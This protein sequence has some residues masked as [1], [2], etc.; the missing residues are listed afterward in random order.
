MLQDHSTGFLALIHRVICDLK[1]PALIPMGVKLLSF[2][3][4]PD[5]FQKALIDSNTLNPLFSCEYWSWFPENS[6]AEWHILTSSLVR[7]MKWDFEKSMRF[8]LALEDHFSEAPKRALAS[9]ILCFENFDLPQRWLFE[10]Y[11]LRFGERIAEMIEAR[12]E[13]PMIASLAT[14]IVR[15]GGHAQEGKGCSSA[16]LERFR[17]VA[18]LASRLMRASEGECAH[19]RIALKLLSLL[20]SLI[21]QDSL[22][23]GLL[24]LY[25]DSNFFALAH[26]VVMFCSRSV[27]RDIK[28]FPGRIVKFFAAFL[29]CFDCDLLPVECWDFVISALSDLLPMMRSAEIRAVFVLI[30]TILSISPLLFARISSARL[31]LRVSFDCVERRPPLAQFLAPVIQA[32]GHEM[33]SW[34]LVN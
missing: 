22:N 31:F 6:W 8:F 32:V 25:G 13:L 7:M 29:E 12:V 5:W 34:K 24:L 20:I 28:K 10:F 17:T 23:F 4:L 1:V 30:E 14:A 33:D 3:P 16:S 19:G 27:N 15:A 2:H 9:L 11:I 26:L 18:D 21:E